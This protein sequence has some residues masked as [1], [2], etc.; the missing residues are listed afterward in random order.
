MDSR[1]C[2]TVS[3]NRSARDVPALAERLD[4]V[5]EPPKG[6]AVNRISLKSLYALP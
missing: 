2:G 5:Y 1:C 6:A 3:G 4:P